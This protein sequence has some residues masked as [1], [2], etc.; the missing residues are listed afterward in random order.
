MSFVASQNPLSTTR[1]LQGSNQTIAKVDA[2]VA[3]TVYSYTLPNNTKR[4]AIL[5]D[6]ACLLK[7]GSSPA[8]IVAGE[9]W[10]V[11]GGASYEEQLL[12]LSGKTIYFSSDVSNDIIRINS[13]A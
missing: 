3:G 10:P 13:W 1:I 8:A 6:E 9:Y 11:E 12:N 7:Y 5:A 2:P 4:F